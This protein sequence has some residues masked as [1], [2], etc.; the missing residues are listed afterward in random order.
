MLRK[1]LAVVLGCAVVGVLSVVLDPVA[2]AVVK[3]FARGQGPLFI[4]GVSNLVAMFFASL[5]GGLV[6]TAVAHERGP[7]NFLAALAF[8]AGLAFAA[9]QKQP[10][11]PPWYPFALPLAGALG[12]FLGGWIKEV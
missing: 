1:V 12:T 10:G 9:S 11:G 4:M 8:I 6:A 3:P 7:A 2:A 5:G